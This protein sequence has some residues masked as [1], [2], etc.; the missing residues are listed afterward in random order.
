MGKYKLEWIDKEARIGPVF[1]INRDVY[2]RDREDQ[3]VLRLNAVESY[4][5]EGVEPAV[6]GFYEL[7]KIWGAPIVFVIQPNLMKPP[8]GRFLFEWSR[9]AFNNNSVDQSYLL[10]T[11][12]LTKWMGRVVLRVFTDSGMPFEAINGEAELQRRLH[13]TDLTCP[14]AG[15]EVV[16]P[17]T[18]MVLHGGG[19][20]T[21]MGSILSR[22][23]RRVSRL[24]G[25]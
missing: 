7:A 18:A 17:N 6:E 23:R 14:R 4:S 22:L 25:S 1:R 8:A 3:R 24:R 11:N 19:P 5:V 21:L 16:E 9:R 2:S 12:T 15:F 10:G 20:T 13:A